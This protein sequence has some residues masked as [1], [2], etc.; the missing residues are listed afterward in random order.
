MSRP[1]RGAWIETSHRHSCRDLCG[2]APYGARGLKH[3]LALA[4]S[5]HRCRAPYGARGL[6]RSMLV[7]DAQRIYMSRPV[8][9]AWIE[10]PQLRAGDPARSRSRPVR[11]AWI[12]TQLGAGCCSAHHGRAPYGARGLK[13]QAVKRGSRRHVSRPVRGAWIETHRRGVRYGPTACV[14]PRTGR[15]D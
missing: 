10:T 4:V 1:V 6:K 5:H 14:A 7:N 13:L 11:G 3:V 8:R 12:E 2:R 15:V 9:G